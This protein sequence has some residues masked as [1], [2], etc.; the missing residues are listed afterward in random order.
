MSMSE[1]FETVEKLQA[2]ILVRN[3]KN[4]E[5]V[6]CY[7]WADDE[8][9]IQ[10]NANIVTEGLKKQLGGG[11]DLICKANF[12]KVNISITQ[13]PIQPLFPLDDP[14]RQQVVACNESI[15]LFHEMLKKHIGG[16]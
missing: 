4:N 13:K 10:E 6:S 3:P 7:V 16:L 9:E 11:D 2:H 5:T 1:A 14:V 8:Y 12:C 15:D